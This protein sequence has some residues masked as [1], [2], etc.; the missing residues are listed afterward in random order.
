MQASIDVIRVIQNL[1]NLFYEFPLSFN[2]SKT[3]KQIWHA[4][5]TDIHQHLQ[6]LSS[7]DRMRDGRCSGPDSVGGIGKHQRDMAKFTWVISLLQDNFVK[8]AKSE[9]LSLHVLLIDTY[10]QTH[11]V[12]L[13]L[14]LFLS[15]SVCLSI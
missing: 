15:T 9:C 4:A 1:I 14:M 11:T 5:N 8:D 6:L 10:T 3:H 2:V 13:F 12:S 7:E